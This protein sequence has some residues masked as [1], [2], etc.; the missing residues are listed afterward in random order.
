[1]R[2]KP[3]VKSQTVERNERVGINREIVIVFTECTM[4][5]TVA[6]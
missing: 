3:N 6:R 1:M 5:C 2:L 4:E